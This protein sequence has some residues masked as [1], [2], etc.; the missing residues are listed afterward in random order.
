MVSLL[1]SLW[2]YIHQQI[3]RRKK[4][5]VRYRLADG[6]YGGTIRARSWEEANGFCIMRGYKLDGIMVTEINARSRFVPFIFW[7]FWP[8]GGSHAG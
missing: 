8:K 1:Q 5:A 6:W 7:L 2:Y 3:T 4:Y